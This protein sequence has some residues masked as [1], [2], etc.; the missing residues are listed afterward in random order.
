MK[1][2]M[3]M[4]AQKKGTRPIIWNWQQFQETDIF[5][6][7]QRYSDGKICPQTSRLLSCFADELNQ[8]HQLMHQLQPSI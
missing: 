7:Y 6:L 4:T 8:N 1:S 3:I 2:D 5:G